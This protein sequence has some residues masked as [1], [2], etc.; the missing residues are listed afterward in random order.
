MDRDNFQFCQHG[1][2]A[3]LCGSCEDEHEV[4]RSWTPEV[5]ADW[6]AE[7]MVKLGWAPAAGQGDKDGR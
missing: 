1:R 7:G 3:D 2:D 6:V 5:K 4:K